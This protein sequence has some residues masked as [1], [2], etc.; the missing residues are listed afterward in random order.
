MALILSN[1]NAEPIEQMILYT[2]S[3]TSSKSAEYTETKDIMVGIYSNAT[4]A[5]FDTIPYSTY[6]TSTS[7]SPAWQRQSGNQGCKIYKSG[8]NIVV[9]AFDP[10]GGI[11]MA[12]LWMKLD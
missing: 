4:G 2:G 8:D 11:S 7:S 6:A 10:N 5:V 1:A 12:V 3:V 9:Q